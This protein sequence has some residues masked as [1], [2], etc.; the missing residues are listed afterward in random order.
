MKFSLGRLSIP[1]KIREDDKIEELIGKIGKIYSLK[2]HERVYIR[3]SIFEA[4]EEY[5]Q[6]QESESLFG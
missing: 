5:R 6:Y 1:I 4:L 3:N 2:E